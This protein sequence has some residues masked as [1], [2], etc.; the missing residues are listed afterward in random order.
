MKFFYI[1]IGIAVFL[2]LLLLLFRIVYRRRAAMLVRMRTDVRKCRD[3]N[4]AVEAFGFRYDICQDIFYSLKNPWQRKTG[5]SSYYDEH[6][7]RMD[8]VLDCEPVYFTY[9]GRS[10]LL[11]IWKGQYGM[12]TGAEIGFY[13]A[14]GEEK[15]HPE[16]CF[17]HSASDEEML[18]MRF[19]LRKKGRILMIRDEIHWWLTGFILGEFSEPEEL[20][21]EVSI[22]FWNGRMRNAFVKAL[23]QAGYER[24]ELSVNGMK[25]SFCF[26]L[27]RTRQPKICKMRISR[28]Q[29]KNKRSCRRFFKATGRFRRTIDRVDYLGMCFPHLYQNIGRMSRLPSEKKCRQIQKKRAGAGC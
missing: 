9:N 11:E 22:G 15:E 14:E 26:A 7:V 8:M 4:H 13:V 25:V 17:Y 6:A 2:L 3:L 10:Y 21:M 28:V 5:Y 1:A 19:I 23:L 16:A 24:R 18:P 20:E 27:P 29:R 12:T